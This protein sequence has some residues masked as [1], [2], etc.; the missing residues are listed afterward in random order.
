MAAGMLQFALGLETAGF[1]GPLG[2]VGR[3]LHAFTGGL[4]SVGGIAH[5]VF[6]A[7]E[8]GGRLADMSARTGADVKSLYQL[9]EAYKVAGLSSETAA[10]HVLKLQKALGGTDEM[11]NKVGDVFQKLG[12]N[13]AQ[14]SRL[15]PAGRMQALLAAVSRMPR[16]EAANVLSKVF[17]RFGFGDILQLTNQL[18]DFNATLKETAKEGAFVARSAF[19]FDALGDAW[20]R[21]KSKFKLLFTG[22]AEGLV[23]LLGAIA[24]KLKGIDFTKMAMQ[25]AR[26]VG[27]IG[28]AIREGKFSELL[29]LGFTAGMTQ[30]MEIFSKAIIAMA[31]F[32]VAIL[33]NPDLWKGIWSV[34]IG[35][36]GKS[37]LGKA[38]VYA[39]AP[40]LQ[41]KGENPRQTVARL[42]DN[43]ITGSDSMM[44]KGMK[45]LLAGTPAAL[46]GLRK[47]IG[48]LGSIEQTPATKALL[49]KMEEWSGKAAAALAKIFSGGGGGG[50]KDGL[51]DRIK[52]RG[53]DNPLARIGFFSGSLLGAP[54]TT[55]ASKTAENTGKTVTVMMGLKQSIDNGFKLTNGFFWANK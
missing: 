24:E 22:L 45:D 28:M 25:I 33:G 46:D 17:G 51:E 27:G 13:V 2:V 15:D 42:M 43:Q 48:T 1:L 19:A 16:D 40:F 3:Y 18:G 7:I 38:M 54:D 49:A 37:P 8:R 30:S 29:A 23:P 4:L 12:L 32:L 50:G 52:P 10:Q 20:G 39:M 47:S 36:L 21:I 31:Q 26:F 9:G 5:G 35:S 55:Y 53:D 6:E 34:G 44:S 41:E 11:G 14:L